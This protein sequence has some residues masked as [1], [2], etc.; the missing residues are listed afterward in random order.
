MLSAE[1][2]AKIK[3][4]HSR[5]YQALGS[6]DMDALA[7][8][9]T[10][11]A[12]FKGF[13]DNVVLATDKKS[14]AATFDMLIAATPEAE[15]TEIRSMEADYVRPNTYMLTMTYAQYGTDDALVHEGRAIY[16]MKRVDDEFKLFAIL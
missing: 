7:E 10:F 13:L 4:A 5:Y 6:R 3:E 15:R 12:A 16:F 14:L 2:E 11:P 8:N 9:F 1:D